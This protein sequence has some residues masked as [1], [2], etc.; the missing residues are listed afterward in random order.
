MPVLTSFSMLYPGIYILYAFIFC[1]FNYAHI[2]NSIHQHF[3]IMF[4]FHK[5]RSTHEENVTFNHA[6]ISQRML[7]FNTQ[8]SILFLKISCSSTIA[9]VEKYLEASWK[10]QQEQIIFFHFYTLKHLYN[11]VVP[12]QP[13]K[14][15][16][17][18]LFVLDC[19]LFFSVLCITNIQCDPPMLSDSLL[20][21][22][23]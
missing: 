4:Y 16:S 21:E 22:I 14:I 9:E 20:I 18:V 23:I 6:L 11:L 7:K 1:V 2:Y 12:S 17:H 15:P 3:T 10:E 19:F 5:H 8:V 13:N